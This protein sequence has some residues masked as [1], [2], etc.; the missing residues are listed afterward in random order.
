MVWLYIYIFNY[1]LGPVE[2]SQLFSFLKKPHNFI[3]YVSLQIL[4]CKPNLF[5]QYFRRTIYSVISF[6]ITWSN[7]QDWRDVLA[8]TL[9]WHPIVFKPLSF[10]SYRTIYY[11]ADWQRELCERQGVIMLEWQVFAY[12]VGTGSK[13]T[14]HRDSI[15]DS[16]GHSIAIL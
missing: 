3:R 6:I 2:R 16:I 7:P 10:V 11:T 13:G 9:I 5:P 4:L 8:A 15:G 12:M 1:I 14:E